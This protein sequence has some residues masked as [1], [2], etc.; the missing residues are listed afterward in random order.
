MVKQVRAAR[1]RQALVR[2][3]AEVFADDGYA[4]ASLPAISRR[5]GVSTG[6]L[7]FHFPS[8]DLLARE[9]EAAATVS[10]QRLAARQDAPPGGVPGGPAGAG[11][12]G[13][14]LRLLVEVSRDLVLGLSA[15]PVLRAGFGLGG[16]PSRKG[17]E[18]P[19]RWWSEWVHALLR[20]AHGA[21]ELAEG[22]SPEAAAVAVVAAT[23]GLAGLASRHRFHLSPHLVEQF[24]A[25]LLPGLA[26]PPPRRPARPG[27]PAAETGPAPR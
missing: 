16:D 18:G 3:A 23:L 7:H 17:G 20:E 1:T 4:L 14:A 19:G 6:A 24:W 22:V 11:A 25:L 12:G 27:I 10:L 15:D 2:A 21:G 9:V 5:A 13:A 26:A 8:K